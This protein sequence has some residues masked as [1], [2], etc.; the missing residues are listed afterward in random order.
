ME[1][2]TWKTV[3]I[4]SPIHDDIKRVILWLG[5]PSV[6]EYVRQTLRERLR[7]DLLY[8]DD[9]EEKMERIKDEA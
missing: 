2:K 8:V 4:P 9:L 6:A 5:V 3:S 1:A 7:R